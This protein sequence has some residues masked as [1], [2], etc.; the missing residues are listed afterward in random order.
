MSIIHHHFSGLHFR[1]TFY[2]I[3]SLVNGRFPPAGIL[4]LPN[5]STSRLYVKILNLMGS[6]LSSNLTSVMFLS[7]SWIPHNSLRP[8][9]S[10]ISSR[11][12]PAFARIALSPAGIST[13]II[14][15]NPQ[16]MFD[17]HLLP[18]PTPSF[19]WKS[20]YPRMDLYKVFPYAQ[21]PVGLYI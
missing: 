20:Y 5:R 18:I 2:A 15:M 6:K 7:A 21:H 17:Q 1:T 12:R 16:Y 14:W 4:A 11:K 9:F 13:S 19:P 3:I 10:A 8:I